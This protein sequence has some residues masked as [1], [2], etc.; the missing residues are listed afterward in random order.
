MAIGLDTSVRYLKGVGPKTAEKLSGLKIHTVKDLLYHFPHRYEDYSIKTKIG[1]LRPN[2]TVTILAEVIDFKN[3]YLKSGKTIQKATVKDKSGVIEVV[4]FNQPFLGQTISTGSRFYFSGRTQNFAGKVS[5]ISSAYE[6]VRKN[7][8]KHRQLNTGRLVPIY[9]ENKNINSKYLRKIVNQSLEEV[10]KDLEEILPQQIVKNNNLIDRKRAIEK[11]HFPK[12]KRELSLAKERLSYEEMFFIQLNHLRKK[13]AQNKKKSHQIAPFAKKQKSFIK[14]LP[15][16]LTSCQEKAIKEIISDLGRKAPMNRLLQGDVGSGKTIVAATAAYI[17][18]LNGYQTVLLVPTEIL[19]FQHY[20]TLKKLFR[21]YKIKV[22]LITGKKKTVEKDQLD[23]YDVFVGTHALLNK[24]QRFKKL[25]LAV[26]DEQHRFGVK[27]RKQIAKKGSKEIAPHLLTM[28]ATP[29]PRT[30]ALA[31]YGNLDLS[32][33]DELPLGRKK[34][35]TFV[36]PPQKRKKGYQWI[37]NEIRK[38]HCQAFIICPFIEPSETR[39]TVRAVKK[40]YLRLK[41]KIYPDLSLAIIHGRMKSSEKQN[42]LKKMRQGKI[43][44]LVSTPVVE[45]GIDIPK[46]TI[47]IIEAAD[48]FGL[49]QLHQLRGRV[50]RSGNKSYC[51]L[52]V[53]EEKNQQ[54]KRLL[55]M[56]TIHNGV[57]LARIDLKTRGP[58]EIYGTRQHGFLRLKLA[59]V[60]DEKL[61][62][63]TRKDISFLLKKDPGLEKCP[64]L[65]RVGKKNNNLEVTNN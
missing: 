2:Q 55:A 18:S 37:K 59:S 1:K 46:A 62:K 53:E 49:A 63:K 51:F 35:S 33:L 34:V 45:V 3:Q 21:S 9:P 64:L 41:N 57:D 23:K 15:F 44:I 28:T 22:G 16:K 32:T 42:V 27:Q 14:N 12:N 50:G 7:Q 60:L 43:D 48:R 29:I 31:L 52:F 54:N 13:Q 24:K 38:N 65:Q 40:E 39:K 61:I 56:K 4:W 25:A 10:K 11:I 26:I 5:L 30:A 17:V 6:L 58:G 36:V 19:A 8:Q 47:I 20:K